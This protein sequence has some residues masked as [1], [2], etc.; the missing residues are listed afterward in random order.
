MQIL[1]AVWLSQASLCYL[2]ILTHFAASLLPK[3]TIPGQMMSQLYHVPFTLA[4]PT[5][6]M[7]IEEPETA[8]ENSGDMDVD[9]STPMGL[10][11]GNAGA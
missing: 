1:L 8:E 4:P 2:L 9:P 11:P 6:G 7:F 5:P 10:A 3:I